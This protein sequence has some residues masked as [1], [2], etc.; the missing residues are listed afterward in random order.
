MMV[1][2]LAAVIKEVDDIQHRLELLQGFRLASPYCRHETSRQ[3]ATEEMA[4]ALLA[5][6]PVRLGRINVIALE[7]E[8]M[9]EKSCDEMVKH[10]T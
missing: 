10:T 9:G 8:S 6:T 2:T 7:T 3:F 1:P 4:F 5:D